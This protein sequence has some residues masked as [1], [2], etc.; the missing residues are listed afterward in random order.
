MDEILSKDIQARIINILEAST[1]VNEFEGSFIPNKI[2]ISLT[3]FNQLV[4]TLILRSKVNKLKISREKTLDINYTYDYEAL[5]NYRLTV[6]A[7]IDEIN[8][9]ISTMID[10][11]N[12]TIFSLLVNKV[13]EKKGITIMDKQKDTSNIIDILEYYIRF[14]TAKELTVSKD[15]QEKLLHL[16]VKDQNSINFRFKDRLSLIVFEDENIIIKT[17]LTEVKSSSNIK[18]LQTSKEIYELEIE[19]VFKKK[20]NKDGEK[21]LSKLITQDN[22]RLPRVSA[23]G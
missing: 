23:R 14:R 17:D 3:K 10:K 4:R 22:H 6:N 7:N 8:N 12:Y 11:K 16:T 19:M 15:N 18:F 13:N 1:E 2:N 9:I 5:K 21:Y 20:I